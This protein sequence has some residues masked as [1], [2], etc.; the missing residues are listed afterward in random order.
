MARPQNIPC[1]YKVD[2]RSGHA[3]G[4]KIVVV[5]L[6]VLKTHLIL[7]DLGILEAIFDLV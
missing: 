4:S 6:E 3:Y 7:V 1:P 2:N 5:L